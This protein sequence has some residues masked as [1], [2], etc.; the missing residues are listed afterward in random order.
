ML[1]E[2]S[3]DKILRLADA[4]QQQWDVIIIGSG[5]GGGCAAYVLANKGYRVLALD[6]GAANFEA[7]ESVS[8]EPKNERQQYV[9]GKWP[10]QIRTRINGKSHDMWAPLG[11]GMGGSS[12]LYAAALQR[13]RAV[14]FEAKPTPAGETIGWPVTYQEMEP[15]YQRAE[16]LFSVCGSKDPL[17]TGTQVALAPPPA[18][19]E[20]DQH[21]FQELQKVGY[22]PYRLH[23]GVQYKKGCGE[24][25]GKICERS[26]KRDAYNSC[27]VPALKSNGLFV[28][29]Y[30]EAKQIFEENGAISA[31]EVEQDGER[32][33]V[34]GT[35]VILAAG[36]YFSPLL[37]MRSRNERW[38]DGLANS[39]GMV[40]KN[41]MFHAS[42][43]LG[44]W[45][46]YKCSRVGPNK[47]IAMRDLYTHNGDKLGELQSTGLAADYGLVLFA[48][49]KI[50]DQ[51]ALSKLKPLRHFLR[52]PAYVASKLYG[53]A[54]VFTTII[55]DYPYR[56]NQIVE[57]SEAPSGMRF[58]YTIHAELKRRV[59]LMRKL[60]RKQIRELRII[61]LN[62]TIDLNYGHPCGTL[63]AGDNPDTSVVDKNCKAHDLDNLYV[64]DASMMP[65]SGGTNPSM[66]IAANALR[67]ANAI[68]AELALREAN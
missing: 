50:F 16:A 20:Q 3:D 1:R 41:L 11:C 61:P 6:K 54:T 19:C 52:I 55:E 31:V 2:I 23:V 59:E 4:Q 5:M 15:Y 28:A 62:L 36:A 44:I 26:C 33:R 40:G 68:A 63:R 7:N 49:R 42:D 35:I 17:E 37:L 24:C 29:E 25:G 64:V 57:D 53:D 8:E 32:Y 10:T 27:I 12:L 56:E 67:V 43:F 60:L 9:S 47:T 39:S 45:P 48:L 65:T 22:H 21:L 51:S 66:T 34:S 58:E 14:D 46:R 30:A 18:M 13:F 38:P